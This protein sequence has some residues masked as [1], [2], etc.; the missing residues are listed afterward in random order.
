MTDEEAKATLEFLGERKRAYLT[1]FA[2]PVSGKTVLKDL[3]QFC[4]A[5]ESC[6]HPDARLHAVAEGRREVF[7]RIQH[8]LNETAEQ[9]LDRYSGPQQE[10]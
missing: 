3:A 10:R 8:H 6:F 9:L 7:L 4:R 2:H 1:L 5:E